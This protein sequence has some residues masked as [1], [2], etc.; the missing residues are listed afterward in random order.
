M[1]TEKKSKKN[2]KF[3][4]IAWIFA[5][6]LLVIVILINVAASF[7]N[8]QID[9][10]PN[11][12]YTMNKTSTEY[13]ENLDKKVDLYFLMEM[14]EIRNAPDADEMLALISLLDQ[15]KEY[16]NINFIDFDP[17]ENPEI[18]SNLN[19][20]NYLN[21][22]SGDIVVK[23]GDV[24]KRIPGKEMYRYE[25][26]YD[27]NGN[28]FAD[29]AYFQGENL[30]T[31][32]IK[33]VAENFT[34]T[35]YFLTGHGEKTIEES[36][37]T[38]RKNLKNNNYEAKELNLASMETVPDDAA[39]IIVAAPQQDFSNSD[40]EKL[41]KYLDNG[42]NL[43]LLMSPANNSTVYTNIVEIM[44]EYCL[45]MDYVR[46]YETDDSRHVSGD[47]YL[48]M[49]QLVDLSTNTDEEQKEKLADLTSA[50]IEDT[51]SL[52]PYMPESRTFFN[53]QGDNY[54]NLNICPLLETYDTAQVEAYGAVKESQDD[55][56]AMNLSD[57]LWLSA[58]SEDP[59]RN[60]SK[61][62]VMGNAEF[63]DDEHLADGYTLVPLYLYL[64]TISWMSNSDINMGIPTREKTADYMT[65]VS[66][67]D[68]NIMI[69]VVVAAPII[70][71]AAGVLIW[72]K[73][74]HS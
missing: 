39:I 69:G 50:L 4:S 9:M 45:G 15:Y 3:T 63:I 68:T 64:S 33:S 43:S 59:T 41:D 38:F 2:L 28:F 55:L 40:K 31:G 52:I 19:P 22:T 51:E 34:P 1:S 16:D 32:A 65:L 74:R 73:R 26:E 10:T 42:G 37:T 71:A 66:E 67:A 5:I 56:R 12:L 61:L 29:A 62:V 20:D 49:A 57:S 46:T 35:I 13:L 21:L 23:C 47:K 6:M 53:Y 72:L 17:D 54:A 7:F 44:H 60:N 25:G 24:V 30:I 48:I 8:V 18:L 70:V 14:D 36:Y 27:S 58:Y 11:K